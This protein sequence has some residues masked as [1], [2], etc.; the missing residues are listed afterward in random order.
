MGRDDR[1]QPPIRPPAVLLHEWV[2]NVT[3][4]DSPDRIGTI[5][6]FGGSAVLVAVP[7]TDYYG[8]GGLSLV[9]ILF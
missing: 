6:L 9:N 7:F 8:G 5:I 4:N 3:S 2:A 1:R